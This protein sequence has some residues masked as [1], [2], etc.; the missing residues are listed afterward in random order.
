MSDVDLT[1]L[2]DGDQIYYNLATQTWKRIDAGFN[3]ISRWDDIIIPIESLGAGASAPDVVA[4]L[5]GTRIYAFDGN[6]I[7]EQ[8]YGSI[9]I[10]HNYKEGT[11]L[12]PHCHFSPLA[13]STGNVKWQIE[14]TIASKDALFPATQ[15]IVNVYDCS[16][17]LN[18]HL[19]SEFSIISG[20]NVKIGD[21]ITFR[22]FRN[23]SDPQDT[24]AGDVG[25]LSFGIHMQ[26]DG[27]GS[28]NTFSK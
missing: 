3:A 24:F 28:R 22:L 18:Y 5:N 21:I 27:D 7:S 4:F 13:N 23:P 26:I 6:A 19:A 9:E 25:L 2:I 16:N 12:R 10:M 1:N 20:T 14:Y 11:D 15:T 17:K 8:L